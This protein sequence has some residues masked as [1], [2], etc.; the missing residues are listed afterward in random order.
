M[1]AAHL[2]VLV[3]EPSMEAFLGALL[4]RLL[5]AERT[6]VVHPFQGKTDLLDKLHD[7]LRGYAAW[8][9]EDWR[10]VAVVDRD[11]DDCLALKRQLETMAHDARLRTRSASRGRPWQL[12]NRIAVEE[13]EA[14]YFGDWPAVCAAYPRVSPRIPDQAGFRHPDGIAGGTW[15]AFERVLS[16]MATSAAG[17]AR[18]RP[19]EHWAPSSSR[20][21]IDRRAS[22]AFAMRCSKRW[23][24]RSRA[25]S[26][27]VPQTHAAR[28]L[29]ILRKLGRRRPIDLGDERWRMHG[30][31]H[32]DPRQGR[33]ERARQLR[34]RGY[35]RRPMTTSSATRC[36]VTAANSFGL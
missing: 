29:G 11:D 35:G 10:I 7:R 33:D 30:E 27:R 25:W 28:R 12:V 24:E 18:S 17:C 22:R 2:E 8:L 14:W 4:P 26:A 13:L 19:R 9:P 23:R 16:G 32:F 6:F 36:C 3:E 21:A 15:E 1:S 31:E 5:P 20:S 34:I